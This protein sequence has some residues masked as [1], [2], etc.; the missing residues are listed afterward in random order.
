MF[1]RSALLAGLTFVLVVTANPLVAVR[2]SP[3]SIPLVKRFNTQERSKTLL[4][5][6][7][8]QLHRRA[9]VGV[10]NEL[11]LYVIEVSESVDVY[12][13][14]GVSLRRYRFPSEI[15]LRNVRKNLFMRLSIFLSDR[16]DTLQLDTGSSNTWIGAGK[17]YTPTSTSKN[18]GNSVVSLIGSLL[19]RSVVLTM[20]DNVGLHLWIWGLLRLVPLILTLQRTVTT[21]SQVPNSLISST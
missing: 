18:T 2:H 5:R 16:V 15:R 19:L 21:V 13:D 10:I 20:R 3:I 17:P 7:R 9:N 4:G 8:Q 6:D 12:Y 14:S 11:V 1:S